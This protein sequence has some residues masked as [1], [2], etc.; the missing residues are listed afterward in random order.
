MSETQQRIERRFQ[1]VG[2]SPGIAR[3]TVFVIRPE[4]VAIRGITEATDDPNRFE[5]KVKDF[6]Y[7]GDVTTY[8]VDLAEGARIEALLPNSAPGRAKFFEVGDAVRVSWK[9]E[10]GAFLDA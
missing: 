10:A 1:G 6:L 9:A 5:G 4:Q 7:I 8:I 3:G 2:V